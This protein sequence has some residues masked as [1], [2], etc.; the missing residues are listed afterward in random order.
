MYAGPS[1]G[2]AFGLTLAAVMADLAGV[3]KVA[4]VVSTI[5]SVLVGLGSLAAIAVF[6]L[7]RCEGST[8]SLDCAA[9]VIVIFLGIGI[10]LF[11]AIPFAI[12][13]A[14]RRSPGA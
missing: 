2:Q 5:G 10:S 13:W 7:G 11:L 1:A 14:R 12:W 4:F 6:Y 8:G 3:R 9:T